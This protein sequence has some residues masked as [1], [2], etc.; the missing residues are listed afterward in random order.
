MRLTTKEL[1]AGQWLRVAWEGSP[2][3][4]VAIVVGEG[5]VVRAF[6]DRDTDGPVMQIRCPDVGPGTFP[7]RVVTEEQTT[8]VGRV[9]IR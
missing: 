9:K 8:Q 6:F 3:T 7:V 1:H 4:A 2:N 5:P